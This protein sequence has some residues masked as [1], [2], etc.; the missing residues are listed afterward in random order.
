M[1]RSSTKT[2][3][4]ESIS[5]NKLK[6]SETIITD[7]LTGGMKGQKDVRI[8]AIP[9]EA[10]FELGRVYAYG[11][12]KYV[13]Y[14]F[15]KGYRWSLSFDALQRHL[16]CFWNREDRDLESGLYHLAHATWHCLTLLFWS[17]TG[18]GTDDR[19]T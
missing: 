7:E 8:H 5:E 17:I 15:R 9:T 13:D 4:S 16:W 19:P 6:N 12:A 11:E 1:P 10:L 2:K 18:K 14:N 3:L